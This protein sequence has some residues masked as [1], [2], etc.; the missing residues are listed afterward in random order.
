MSFPLQLLAAAP[1]LQLPYVPPLYRESRWAL[2]AASLVRDPV[3][4]GVGV[5]RGEGRPVLLIPGF[6]AGDGSLGIMTHWLRELGYR[7]KSA[8]IRFNVDCSD[9][10]C[11]RLE[12]RLECLADRYGQ[13]VAIVGQS[14]GGIFARALAV[15]RPELVSGIVTL[16]SPVCSMFS[17]HP[18]VAAQI[19]VMGLLSMTGRAGFLHFSCLNGDCC[20]RFRDSIT[21][22]FPEDVRFVSVYSRSDGIV[23]WRACL[24]PEADELVEVRASHCGMSTHAQT[25][26]VIGRALGD[27]AAPS[28]GERLAEAA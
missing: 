10:A 27:F 24:D 6:M 26:R 4:R 20:E 16:G 14:R 15:A 22:P 23:D 7:T 12:E 2:E 11:H 1:R 8:G 19:G 17:V 3:F 5:P 9:A 18:L 21:A 28:G 25:Y 13:R